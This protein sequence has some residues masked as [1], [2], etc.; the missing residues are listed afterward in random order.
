VSSFVEGDGIAGANIKSPK[1][2][3]KKKVLDMCGNL[4]YSS[5]K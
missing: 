3:F 5:I 4:P 2:P 1:S